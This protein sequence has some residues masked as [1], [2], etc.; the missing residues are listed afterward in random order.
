LGVSSASAAASS[1][2]TAELL[3]QRH[4]RQSNSSQQQQQ[5]VMRQRQLQQAHR[6]PAAA[7]AAAAVEDEY[8]EEGSA[9]LTAAAADGVYGCDGGELVTPP[10]QLLRSG[11]GPSL[12]ADGAAEAAGSSMRQC[13]VGSSTAHWSMAQRQRLRGTVH[14]WQEACEGSIAPG[15]S[16]AGQYEEAN[17]A[18]DTPAA[19]NLQ[20]FAFGAGGC[21]HELHEGVCIAVSDPFPV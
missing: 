13:S 20:Q 3:S 4:S 1:V 14:D 16:H 15:L 9:S 19:P 8:E 10:R 21:C 18:T 6:M 17:I 12:L 5:Q 2:S 11:A 7:A